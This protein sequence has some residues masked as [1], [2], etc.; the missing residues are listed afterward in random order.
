MP[1]MSKPETHISEAP[2][3]KAETDRLCEQ[4]GV[5]TQ[6][7]DIF[8]TIQYPG[9]EV[10]RAV[11][12]ALGV[13]EQTRSTPRPNTES[14]PHSQDAPN[15]L[16]PDVIVLRKRQPD[17]S[18][19]G[20]SLSLPENQQA[21]S[22]HW[23]VIEESGITVKGRHQLEP[24]NS[25][26]EIKLPNDINYGYHQLSIEARGI[27]KQQAVLI[28]AP[29]YCYQPPELKSHKKHN[30]KKPWSINIQLYALR[31]KRN[32]GIGDF[33]DL[34]NAIDVFAP[35]GVAMIGLNPLHS[36]FLHQPQ[37]ASPYSPSSRDYLNP[38]Y[39]DIEAIPEFEQSPLAQSR[40]HDDGFQTRLDQLRQQDIINHT[41]VWQHKL[42]ILTILYR[43]FREA[44][45]HPTSSR[46]NDFKRVT[47]CWRVQRL[48]VG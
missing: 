27:E 42:E 38:I 20:F 34:R 44:E 18:M 22:F 31:S 8:G 4:H 25:A 6:Y 29:E 21:I 12:S 30:H 35:L 1:D 17:E 19:D 23:T 32:W 48:K 45:K 14:G 2:M 37:W 10:K 15:S 11:L 46:R 5:A 28:V 47:D 39:L 3:D 26:N 33:T 41:D 7:Q 9:H 24:G 43:G 36:L 40:F 13:R 16:L